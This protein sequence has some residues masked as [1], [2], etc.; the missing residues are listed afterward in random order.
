MNI[1]NIDDFINPM[2]GNAVFNL[3]PVLENYKKH[4]YEYY[5][6]KIKVAC[7]YNNYTD[8]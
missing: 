4:Y 6:S 3:K 8:R 7:V 5:S 1:L 2:K